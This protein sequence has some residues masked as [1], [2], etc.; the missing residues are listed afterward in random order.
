MKKYKVDWVII[1][2]TSQLALELEKKPND[3]TKDYSDELSVI[4]IRK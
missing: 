3:W 4:Y 1:Q 2:R